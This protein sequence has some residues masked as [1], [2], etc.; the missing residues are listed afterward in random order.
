MA[1]SYRR[2]GKCIAYTALAGAV[3]IGAV[4][5][6]L[7]RYLA[8]SRGKTMVADRLGSALGMPVEVSEIDLGDATSSFGFRVM[9]PSDPK[10]EVLNVRSASTD[11]TAADLVTGRVAPSALNLTGVALT[12]RVGTDGHIHNPLPPLPGAGN[13]VP[14]VV[15]TGGRVCIRQE[16][17]PEFTIGGANLKLEP[18]GEAGAMVVLSGTVADEKWGRWTISGEWRR[19]SRT[20]WVEV[21]SADFVLNA[22]LLATIPTLP[23]GTFDNLPTGSHA[24]VTLRLTIGP[25]QDVQPTVEIRRTRTILGFPIIDA[26]RLVPGSE[27]WGF[28]LAP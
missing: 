22:E 20:G 27:Q 2:V 15:V 4:R 12:L 25:D 5:F 7:G 6:G 8:S 21:K 26:Y 17:R 16:G 23:T 28:E 3:L 14:T 10:A 13:A 11:V 9:D 18:T 19:D 24:A 1:F